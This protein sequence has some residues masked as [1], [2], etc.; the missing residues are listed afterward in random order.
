MQ[1]RK[2]QQPINQEH[3]EVFALIK[4]KKEKYLAN[5]DKVD[6]QDQ[7]E[8]TITK[9][10]KKEKIIMILGYSTHVKNGLACKDKWSSIFKIFQKIYDYIA[11]TRHNKEYWAMNII[12][13]VSFKLPKSF[14]QG[15]YDMMVEFLGL[16]LI[17]EPPHTKNLVMDNAYQVIKKFN[18]A[19]NEVININ[20]D[21]RSVN[22][23]G[24]QNFRTNIEKKGCL[25]IFQLHQF[26]F[27]ILLGTS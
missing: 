19:P 16:R 26:N 10:K 7:I 12:D 8:T 23:K 25:S 14:G 18:L 2:P 13:K 21:S 22:E 27:V 20:D 3:D 17:F 15:L 5:C 6:G 24:Q 1:S 4:V 9:Q 11:S